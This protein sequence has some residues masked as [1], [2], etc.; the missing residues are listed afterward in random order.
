LKTRRRRGALLG[1]LSGALVLAAIGAGPTAPA[2]AWADPASSPLREDPLSSIDD[3]YFGSILDWSGDSVADQS[4]RLGAPS[5]V[6]EHDA[7]FPLTSTDESYLRQYFQQIDA[8]GALAEIT[9]RPTILLDQVTDDQADRFAEQLG[10]VR[11]S[12]DAPVWVRFAPD[13]NANW[14]PWGQHP[15]AYRAAFR[16]VADA[17][18]ATL[19]DAI[20]A[21]TPVWGGDYPF[22][23]RAPATDATASL[24]TNGDAAVDTLDD[25]YAPY[26]PGDDAVDWVGLT[27]YHDQTAGGAAVNTIPEADAF[28]AK[29]GPPGTLAPTG[30]ET[31]AFYARYAADR[32][33]PF[34]LET[35]AFFSPTA[36]GPRELPVKQAWW[37]QVFEVVDSGDYPLLGLVIWRDTTATRAVAGE[38]V[39]DWSVTLDPTIAAAFSADIDDTTLRLGPVRT[40]DTERAVGEAGWTIT[41]PTAWIVVIVIVVLAGTLFVLAYR[42]RSV[43]K[44]AYEG[45]GN[46]DLR[47]DMFRGL[48]I[49]FVVINHVGLVS[50]FQDVTQEFIGVVSGAELFVLLS[51]TVLGLVYRPKLVSG[52]IGEVV[53][54]TTRRAWKLY[55]TALGVILLIFFLTLIPGVDGGYV[56][57][58]TDQGTGGAGSA[59]SGRIYDLYAGADGL[60]AYPVDPSIVVDLL[61]LRLGPWQFNVMGLYVIL[62]LV[63]PLV[64]WLLSRRW[65]PSV[66]AGSVAL[67]VVGNLTRFR[68]L[69][70][71]FED[72]FPLL[73]WQLLFT[74]G[75]TAGFYR[76]DIVAWF[77][78]RSGTIVLAGAILLAVAFMI[79]SWNNPYV[80]S[81]ADLRL[82]LIPDNAFRPIYATWFERTYLDVGRLV[83]VIVVVIAAYALLTA[84]WRPIYKTRGWF[85][86]PLGQATLYVFI[87]HVFFA[88]IAANVPV[89]REGD[90][91]VNTAANIVIL[92]LLWAM[93]KSRF[94]FRIVPR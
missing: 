58:F 29:L 1:A 27:I 68:L 53:I 63:S 72:S 50:L 92:G 71:Q 21:W 69:P 35:A 31:S 43:R 87:M 89:L 42:S 78:R 91:W 74:L 55:Y 18:H 82:A 25:P 34:L 86:I 47:I 28:L 44:L 3:P 65:W 5:A 66:L 77:Q 93:V 85:L 57:T 9:V 62:L 15:D 64:L 59:A 56:T 83:N 49:V 80:A 73:T 46:R 38:S 75:I 51:G 41:G 76:R 84:Y 48:A 36:G 7:S 60:L 88:L 67:Y 24:D 8:A 20:M 54:R 19:P 16:A 32:D 81:A 26:Y 11:E 40:P 33:K 61:L 45:P 4:E 13:M 39:I 6:Y 10:A 22:R 90:V 12:S 52:G 70:S 17:I 2:S 94:L 23:P 79:F 37:T 30:D 14:V